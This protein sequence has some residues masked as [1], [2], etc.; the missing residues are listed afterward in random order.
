MAFGAALYVDGGETGIGRGGRI[1]SK[2][3]G[4][5]LFVLLQ[6][7]MAEQ[8]KIVS[9]RGYTEVQLTEK[10]RIPEDYRII[11]VKVHYR[12]RFC[13]SNSHSKHVKT[14]VLRTVFSTRI[15]NNQSS[16]VTDNA[17]NCSVTHLPVFQWIQLIKQR[18]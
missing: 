6:N 11:L 18:K 12:P 3:A 17:L 9:M 14:Q 4:R 15:P 7:Y 13:T 5:H 2:I 8:T 10:R 1:H 16:M